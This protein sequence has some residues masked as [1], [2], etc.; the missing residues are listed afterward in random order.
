VFVLDTSGSMVAE[1]WDDDGDPDTPEVTR[2]RSLRDEIEAQLGVHGSQLEAGVQRFP[3]A[4]ACPDATEMEPSCYDAQACVTAN[5]PEVGVAL[6][7]G[8][9]ILAALPAPDAGALEVIGQTPTSAALSSAYAHLDA[10]A[11]GRARHVVLVT[12]GAANCSADTQLPSLLE[13]YDESA[14]GVVAQAWTSDIVQTWVV[15]VELVD[16]VV[17][18][19]PDDGV[20]EANPRARAQELAAAGA[21]QV[22]H[23]VDDRAELAAALDTILT[24]VHDC[25]LDLVHSVAGPPEPGVVEMDLVSAELDGV[26]QPRVDSCD[27]EDGWRWVVAGE[28]AELCGATCAG[29]QDGAPLDF[30]YDCYC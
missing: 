19:A 18:Q 27:G 28:I 20:A 7:N 12:D 25:E 9:A 15:G 1:T 11:S 30:V 13:A 29:Y 26:E 16:A 24:G 8:A 23:V 6:D 21:T 2:W 10:Q 17:G 22:V 3:A 5:A 14:A 4:G